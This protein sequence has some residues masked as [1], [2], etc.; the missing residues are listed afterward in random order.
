M[1]GSKDARWGMPEMT[2]TSPQINQVLCQ[3][4]QV[5]YNRSTSPC[6]RCQRPAESFA[7]AERTAIDVNLEHPV[8]LLVTISVHYCPWCDHYFRAQ[9]PFLRPKAI[10]TNQVV[11][12]AIQS[13]YEDGMAMRRVTARMARDF[14]VQPSEGIIRHWCRSYGHQFDFETDYQ[15]WV[16]SEF[17]GVLCVDE[18]YQDRLALLLAVDPA[19]P[20]G[21]RI[22]GYQLIHGS[23]DST[24]VERFLERLKQAGIEP[25]E[26]IT[27]GSALY[28]STLAKIWP[29]AAHQLCLFHQTR[30]VTQEV[31]KAI[32]AV[33]KK[34]PQPPPKPGTDLKGP[35]HNQPPNEDP[36][37]PATQRWY[38]RQVQRR[39][40]IIQ[41]HELAQQGLS[42]RA[43]SRQTG[44]HRLTVK[45]WLQQP[46]PPLPE[47]LP[48]ELSELACLPAPEQR[49]QQKQ[50]LKRQVHALA[51]QGLSYSEIARR[52]GIHR[53]TV[54]NWLQQ[55]PPPVEA[56][57]VGESEHQ[58][59]VLPPPE[60]WSSWDQVHQVRE[61]LQNDRFLLL[62]R[63][64]H[65]N[66]EEQEQVNY[67][68]SCPVGPE[69][70]V[71]HSFLTDWYRFWTDEE[72]QRRSPDEAQ[73]HY[74]AWRENSEY[75]AV[76]RLSRLQRKITPAKFEQLSQFLRQP[77]WKATSNGAERAC[78]AFRHLQLPI[79]ICAPKI[80]LN[81]PSQ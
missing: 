47:G 26:V 55:E 33:R 21:D 1:A 62:R 75:Q 57:P 56:Q 20:D 42:Q 16:V 79:S 32:N 66:L 11:D 2:K 54:T 77:E 34:L 80:T 52:V 10:Y 65:L 40:Y 59:D 9:P 60:P 68:L 14:W 78:R 17:S 28:P 45:K 51:R 58:V 76:S 38:W 24:D 53:V 6:D 3:V 70:R 39:A 37:D 7:T 41:V 81:E 72:G 64:E 46:I 35:L 30:R 25:D 13:V 44:H 50:A 36:S 5:H 18:V 8:L 22:V 67:L 71:I 69:L 61:A 27:D 63:P 23:V 31:M 74:Q 48:D 15:P 43:I 73:A 19:A 12:K 49:K 29:Q 4:R